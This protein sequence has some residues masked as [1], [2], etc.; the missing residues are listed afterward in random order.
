MKTKKSKQGE[1][2][3]GAKSTLIECMVPNF[4]P[5]AVRRGGYFLYHA[6]LLIH[7]RMRITGRFK[8]YF[9]SSAHGEFISHRMKVVSS[10][11]VCSQDFR[12]E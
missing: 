6:H 3:G 10:V 1:R 7:T 11:V 12:D 5:A 9:L 2:A 8:G 4:R